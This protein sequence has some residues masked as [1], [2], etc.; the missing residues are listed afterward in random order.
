MNKCQKEYNSYLILCLSR[1]W[2]WG[3]RIRRWWNNLLLLLSD[4]ILH[5]WIYLL[6]SILHHIRSILDHM[7]Q[8]H[9][10]LIVLISLNVWINHSYLRYTLNPII[11][12]IEKYKIYLCFNEDDTYPVGNDKDILL[13]PVTVP[14]IGP[15]GLFA[16]NRVPIGI[17]F[18]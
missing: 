14:V 3:F 16:T 11:I 4:D 7:W 17:G 10:L 18:P 8:H 12:S 2:W 15:P 13:G 9:P 1:I 6:L 5:I